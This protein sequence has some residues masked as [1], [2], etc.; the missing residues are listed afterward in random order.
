AL[1]SLAIDRRGGPF[2]GA[3]YVAWTQ[4]GTSDP[5]VVFATSTDQG[6]SWST[7][8]LASDVSSN[9]QYA[10]SVA[11]DPQGTVNF[12]FYDAR[13]DVND[14]R[15][16]RYLSRSSDGG[17]TIL[18]N[19]KVSDVDFDLT[20]GDGYVAFDRTGTAASDRRV[21]AIWTDRRG[22]DNDIFANSPT[23]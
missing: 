23:P 3:L 20:S 19:W 11:V 18:P 22:G 17:A 5:D 1:P 16:F 8:V 12:T 4:D 21:H 6:K 15:V 9:S 13:D 2:D 7:P 10:P 14:R